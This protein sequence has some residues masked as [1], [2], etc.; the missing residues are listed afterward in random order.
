MRILV[1]GGDGLVGRAIAE[2]AKGRGIDAIALGRTA[3]DVTR[4]RERVLDTYRPDAVIFCAAFTTVDACSPLHAAVNVDA[5]AEW[6]A[7]V[8]TWFLSSNFVLSGD[9]PHLPAAEPPADIAS[10][11]LYVAQKAE[12][13]RRVR[14][15]GGHVARVGW[16]YGPGGKTFASF[17][18]AKLRAGE[19]VRAISD[20]RVRPTWAADLADALLDLPDGVSHHSSSE[21]TTWYAFALAVQAR[22]GSGRV[23]PVTLKELGLTAPRPRDSR[24]APA[25]LAPWWARID[26]LVA[27]T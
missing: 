11:G 10:M 21:D 25:V 9:G 16:V 1:T 22:V 5:P 2:R 19:T 4:D 18:A 12:A 8:P 27:R 6:A 24:L 14:A 3:C 13:E 26:E 20:V 7:R 15:A 23:V 17:V